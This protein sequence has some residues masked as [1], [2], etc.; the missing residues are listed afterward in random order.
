MSSRVLAEP[1]DITSTYGAL[2]SAL[3]YWFEEHDL[4]ELALTHRS[5]CAE[6][7]G[8][9]SNERLEFLGDAVL[10]LSITDSLYHNEPSQAEGQL[11][12][13]RAEVV[14][15]PVLASIAQ[16]L[17][18]GPLLRLGRG[19]ELSGGREKESILAD[20]MEA[21]MAAVYLDGGW[22]P[23]RRVVI[24]LLAGEAAKA[25]TNPGEHDYKTRLQERAAELSLQSPQYEISSTGPDHGRIFMSTVQVATIEGRGSGTSKKQAQQRAAE[26]ALTLLDA[27]QEPFHDETDPMEKAAVRSGG[28]Q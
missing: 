1:G 12:K 21:V 17:D 22:E 3:G 16:S 4:L 18:I 8:A 26:Q 6:H 10:G 5:W 15:A 13:A 9:P 11:A 19:E 25:Q 14:S 28:T 23:A 27:G 2:C 24:G 20:A 7:D